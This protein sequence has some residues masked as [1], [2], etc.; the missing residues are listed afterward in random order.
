MTT[1]RLLPIGE[2]VD[3][4]RLD[5]INRPWLTA[6]ET[7]GPILDPVDALLSQWARFTPLDLV[8]EGVAF[9]TDRNGLGGG[10]VGTSKGGHL[11]NSAT[12]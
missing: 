1:G 7:Q 5:E 4:D 12:W 2:T 8:P 10:S 3:T 6:L 11:R 9:G